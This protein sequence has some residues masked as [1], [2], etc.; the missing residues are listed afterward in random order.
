[1]DDGVSTTYNDGS[2][3]NIFRNNFSL[4]LDG[5]NQYAEVNT[6]DFNFGY[7]DAFS[8]EF[9]VRNDALVFAVYVGTYNTSPLNGWR[10]I[11]HGSYLNRG[12]LAFQLA[13]GGSLGY[14]IVSNSTALLTEGLWHHVVVTKPANNVATNARI[15]VNGVSVAFTVNNTGGTGTA[16]F[17]DKLT[18]GGN[19]DGTA[20]QL[21]ANFDNLSIYN[22]ELSAAEVTAHYGTGRPTDRSSD[23]GLVGYW[24]FENNYDDEIGS[25]DF[26]AYNS[27]T[28]SRQ[29]P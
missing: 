5:V 18:I 2:T 23:S 12:G 20:I 26:T 25:N 16:T 8:V 7:T 6:T 19:S 22:R 3:V 29:R 14:W 15:Y 11:R 17:L 13:A 21:D 24:K 9:W 4:L 28:F 10:V 27:P 1:V